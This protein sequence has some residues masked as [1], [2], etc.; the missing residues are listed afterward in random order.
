MT[1]PFEHLRESLNELPADDRWDVVIARAAEPE[2]GWPDPTVPRQSGAPGR[3]W[4]AAAAVMIVV[5]AGIVVLGRGGSGDQLA[6]PVATT[7]GVE[8][9]RLT[10]ANAA[11]L[12]TIVT[13]IGA[14]L[15]GGGSDPPP[16]EFPALMGL[17]PDLVL[18]GRATAIT[19]DDNVTRL[20]LADTTVAHGSAD[21]TAIIVPSA[22]VALE[23]DAVHLE[24]VTAVAFL[25]SS[26]AGTD[27]EPEPN[28]LYIGCAAT[29]VPATGIAGPVPT[30]FAGSI[31]DISNYVTRALD[32][33]VSPTTPQTTEALPA[34]STSSP[35]TEVEPAGVWSRACV[36]QTGTATRPPAD[37]Y[38][39]RS[40][41]PLAPEP[42][43]QI[44]YPLNPTQPPNYSAP[45]SSVR[46]VPGG[47]FISL[48][49]V[50]PETGS[51]RI[52]AVVDDDGSVRWRQCLSDKS[53][54][55]TVLD[56]PRGVIDV[57]VI[58]GGDTVGEW[59]AFD[60]LTGEY[61]IET[62]RSAE[63]LTSEA[64]ARFATPQ[65]GFDLTAS[66]DQSTLR[67]LDTDGSVVWR[68]D[69]LFDPGGEGF[70]ASGSHSSDSDDV[71]LVRAC[72]GKP[73]APTTGPGDLP[74]P[75]AL[76]GVGTDDGRTRWQRDGSYSVS[77]VAHG[78]AIVAP[79][80]TLGAGYEL[81]ALHTGEVVPDGISPAPNAFLTE[82]CGGY[83]YNR[84]EAD[85]AVAWTI[86]TDILN[87]WYPNDSPGP[88]MTVDLLGPSPQ[89]QVVARPGL[90][91]DSPPGCE[92]QECSEVRAAGI[93][94][95]P[96]TTVSA[97]CWTDNGNG[98]TQ[99]VDAI[100]LVVAVD[101][102][103]LF[104]G[105]CYRRAGER[106]KVTIANVDSNVL[107]D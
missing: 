49:G 84:T 65:V 74:C 1:D 41:G 23:P 12:A 22:S 54:W 36:D 98:W 25:R 93:G 57:E 59:W 53:G 21:A 10:C 11:D 27:W 13:R 92:T 102:S 66:A 48:V 73:L 60:L 56:T 63:E 62:H 88:G 47:L 105:D 28:G 61:E 32:D 86:A 14:D 43:L 42:G 64:G 80:P 45:V 71:T 83:D 37:P 31:D 68:R 26:G 9:D 7:A 40:F 85:R 58:R 76:L 44:L 6:T 70:R 39:D 90:P 8:L 100:D 95:T 29:D 3:W 17:N 18:V 19:R 97:V 78:Y 33:S 104:K 96:D 38:V 75:Y 2:P 15:N 89:P 87:V 99:Q 81:I 72:V 51:E 103:A 107:A 67:R 101:G 69:D 50:A 34:T 55:S 24:G 82:C 77:I 52:I 30:F 106:V 35:A 4:L 94:F 20:E 91:T 16:A 5:V 46:R 79:T